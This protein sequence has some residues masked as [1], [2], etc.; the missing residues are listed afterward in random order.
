MS[1]KPP[2]PERKLGP[3]DPAEVLGKLETPT[4]RWKIVAQ[5]AAVLVALWVLSF[6]LRPWIGWWGV[7]GTAV[8]TALVAGFGLYAWRLMRRSRRMVELLRKATTSE[9]RAEALA[10]LAADGKDA[11][12]ALARS[13]LLAQE[14]P[15]EAIR[16]LEA[17][18]LRRAPVL[19]QDD[20]RANLAMLYLVVGR[21][22]DARALAEVIRLDRQPQPKAKALYAAVIAEAFARTGKP[23]EARTLLE[24][25][26]PTDPAY[27]EVAALLYRAQVYTYAA[28]R[29]RGLARKAMEALLQIEPN[30]VA[31]FVKS[32][33]PE[34]VQMARELL[35]RGG[36]LPRPQMRVQ[37]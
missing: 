18:D 7:A 25:Y 8:L 20:V 37:R 10:E 5:V 36:L 21:T 17:V 12:A 19:V 33:N 6:G 23:A 29:N 22:T 9:G 31:A 4:V 16:V 32:K 34:L 28:T 11:L 15:H 3:R 13:Q 14:D 2:R 35:R 1:A 26:P 24:T 27:G 30:A